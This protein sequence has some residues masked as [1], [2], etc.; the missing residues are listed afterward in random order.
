MSLMHSYR[1]LYKSRYSDYLLTQKPIKGFTFGLEIISMRQL[2]TLQSVLP[3]ALKVLP[4]SD[5]LTVLQ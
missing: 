1:A 3:V 5:I 4:N 2:L